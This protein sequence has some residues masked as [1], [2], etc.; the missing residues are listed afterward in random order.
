MKD[1]FKFCL[2][3][4]VRNFYRWIS[5][6]HCCYS[7]LDKTMRT[8]NLT[9]NR[10][11]FI[12]QWINRT[13][14]SNDW[15]YLGSSVWNILWNSWAS[16]CVLKSQAEYNLFIRIQLP[17]KRNTTSAATIDLDQFTWSEYFWQSKVHTHR[18]EAG[19]YTISLKSY[20]KSNEVFCGLRNWM[21]VHWFQSIG[22]RTF[23]KSISLLQHFERNK[24][25][26]ETDKLFECLNFAFAFALNRLRLQSIDDRKS[27]KA[28]S[29]NQVS[30]LASYS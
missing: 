30:R 9:V 22:T 12:E 21:S 15:N 24:I 1:C 20:F 28:F 14:D 16:A 26:F 13:S 18:Y 19:N 5:Q 6:Y 10:W 25:G 2:F 8:H 23:H 4:R 7:V 27:H 29:S 17:I 3:Q 11:V